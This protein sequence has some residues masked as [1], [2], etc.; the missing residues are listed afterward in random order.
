MER[1]QA[2]LEKARAERGDA[3]ESRPI[4][5]SR[6]APQGVSATKWTELKPIELDLNRLYRQRIIA[7]AGGKD[8]A[9]FDLLRTRLLQQ[10]KANSWRRFAI[11]SPS[12]GCGK[13]TVAL[14]LA[15]SLG[16]QRELK[17]MLIEIDLRR[18]TLARLVGL[19]GGESFF[20]VLEGS[21]PFADQ[22]VRFG[23]NVSISCNFGSADDPA[24]LLSSTRTSEILDEIEQAYKPD[25]M[26]FDMPPMLMTDD[27]IAFASNVDAAMLIAAAGSS[28]TKQ[29]DVCERD[30]AANTNFL[31]VVLNKC[32]FTDGTY[33]YEYTY[34]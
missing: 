19:R 30:L 25:I 11:T 10:A 8:A 5:S 9:L 21:V 14:N 7:S 29:I 24:E 27:N 16:R 32:R 12:T 23:E 3:P 2:A 31:G 28:T 4:R 6:P 34:E 22:A 1:L 13:T 26:L 18:P 15:L 20:K 17:T 33:G